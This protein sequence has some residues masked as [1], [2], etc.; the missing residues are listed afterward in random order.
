MCRFSKLLLFSIFFCKDGSDRLMKRASYSCSNFLCVVLASTAAFLEYCRCRLS[1]LPFVWHLF[2]IVTHTQRTTKAR[3][4][5]ITARTNRRKKWFPVSAAWSSGYVFFLDM[6]GWWK[7]MTRLV[8]GV[9][10]LLQWGRVE[11]SVADLSF[12]YFSLKKV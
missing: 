9:L 2:F 3:E 12:H 8:F 6:N 5:W 4:V 11:G 7:K 1:C 10:P